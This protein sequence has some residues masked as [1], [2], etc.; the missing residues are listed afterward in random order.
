MGVWGQ[1]SHNPRHSVMEFE[2]IVMRYEPA[3]CLVW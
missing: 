2:A 1:A 3:T